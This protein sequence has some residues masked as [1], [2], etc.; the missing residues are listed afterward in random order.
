MSTSRRSGPARHG[1]S[2]HL[3]TPPS[4]LA[5]AT[6]YDSVIAHHELDPTGY[7]QFIRSPFVDEVLAGTDAVSLV[8][9]RPAGPGTTTL[10]PPGSLPVVVAWIG[11]RLGGVGPAE[12]DVVV[13][14]S[15]V[16]QLVRSVTAHPLAA[17]TLA[18][19]LR[20]VEQCDL[21]TGLA[22][23]STAYSLLQG[24]PEFAAWR[25]GTTT[26]L[27]PS[28]APVV[29][30][31][32][33]GTELAITLNRPERHNAIDAH[34]RDELSAAL[35]VAIADPT[36]E[37]VRLDGRGPSFC[38]GG[39]LAEFGSRSDPVEAH[40]VRLARSPARQ[41]ARLGNVTAYLHGAAFGGGIE[42]AAF[43]RRV[44]AH[45]ATRIALPEIALGLIPGAGGTVS[46]TR[47]CGRQRTA[48]LALTGREIDAETALDWGL[49]DELT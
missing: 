29:L 38:S 47:R 25:A 15:D 34:L 20:A 36:I 43:A 45:R 2:N 11:D 8:V 44:V 14:E 28:S 41:I 19:L 21:D 17:V 24:G 7:R 9:V 40:L 46:L 35:A 16:D 5:E 27:G 22:L 32:R 39:D 30:T 18:V 10:P 42:M 37:T 33:S 31:D 6:P 26:T 48:A 3:G 4:L 23:E 13:G 1:G 12:A 49:V